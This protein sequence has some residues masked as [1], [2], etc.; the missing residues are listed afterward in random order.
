M[1]IL[2]IIM[3]ASVVQSAQAAEPAHAK[4]LI[5]E[6][7]AIA[8]AHEATAQCLA[9]GKSEKICHEELSKTCKTLPVI[10][11]LCGMRKHR[12]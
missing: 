8:A 12:H 6:H 3:L 1:R 5:E 10:G 11:A 7:R 2:T 4:D 9:S